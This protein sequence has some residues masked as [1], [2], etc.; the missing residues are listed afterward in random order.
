MGSLFV[1]FEHPPVDG[2]TD[3]FETDEE[4]LVEQ[5]VAHRTVEALDV[6]VL[7]GLAGLDVLDRHAGRFGPLREGVA[8]KLG[9]I[10]GSQHL[11]QP[12]FLAQPFEDTDQSLRRDRGV[13]LHLQQFAIEIVDDVEEPETTAADQRVAHEVR[14]PDAV[15]QAGD[16]QRYP[17]SLGQSSL[18][19]TTQIE[20][21]ELVHPIDPLVIPGPALAAQL[22]A[23][24]PETAARPVLDQC[25]QGRD[26]LRIAHRPMIGLAIERG[27]RQPHAVAGA[28]NGHVV[29]VHHVA[30]RR[31]LGFRPYSF[32]R[33]NPS[34][35]D[36]RALD[37]RTCA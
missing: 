6:A 34:S 36:S 1:V 11:R 37:P 35:R 24:H 25:R 33:S 21:H 27:P 4:M 26:D 16:I 14:R 29:R 9:T 5:L 20:L 23:A 17:F 31:S 2:F 30:G 10:V 32:L 3:V 12:A 15:R 19:R 8:Q 13:D 28:S 22:L 7:V 18:R